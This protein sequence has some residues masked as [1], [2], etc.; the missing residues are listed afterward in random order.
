[1]EAVFEGPEDRVAA[2]VEWCRHGPPRAQVL[3]LQVVVEDPE[4][5]GSFTVQ[6]SD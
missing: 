3:S 5:L 2:M 6:G 1:M 4:S